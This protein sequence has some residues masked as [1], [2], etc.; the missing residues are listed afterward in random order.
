MESLSILKAKTRVDYK[1]TLLSVPIGET[2]AIKANGR[3]YNGLSVAA[4]RLRKQ[5]GKH[6]QSDPVRTVQID[7]SKTA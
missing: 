6:G 7:P 3:T 2:R 1:A 5:G 4:T